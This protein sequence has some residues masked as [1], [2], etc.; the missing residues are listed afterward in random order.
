MFSTALIARADPN[1]VPELGFVLSTDVRGYYLPNSHGKTQVHPTDG[2]FSK[3]IT[4]AVFGTS[5]VTNILPTSYVATHSR[6]GDGKAVD[7]L[8]IYNGGCY[9]ASD[10]IMG[11]SFPPQATAGLGNPGTFIASSIVDQ[12]WATRVVLISFGVGGSM[13]SHWANPDGLGKR[14]GIA[15]R[16]AAARGLSIDAWL[17]H[18]GENDNGI[19]PTGAATT[20]LN[21]MIGLIRDVSAAPIFIPTASWL[22]APDSNITIAERS[23]VSASNFVIQGF[24]SDSIDGTGR[25]DG[26]HFND[27]GRALYV[28]GTIATFASYGAPFA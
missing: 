2:G 11:P 12:G 17:A 15:Y 19:T 10:P 13:F 21:A 16:L 26:T 5:M 4:L 9:V 28:A 18:L 20:S 6:G 24:N 1:V 23:V 8:C 3:T 14:I 25:Q 7:E 22:G 27:A